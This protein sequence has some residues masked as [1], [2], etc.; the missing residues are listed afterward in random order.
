[1]PKTT[2]SEIEKKLPPTSKIMGWTVVIICVAFLVWCCYE[3]HRQNDL[4]PLA[5]IGGEIGAILTASFG[6]YCWRAKATD[7]FKITLLKAEL[8][9]QEGITINTNVPQDGE[10]ENYMGDESNGNYVE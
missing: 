4:A 3:M 2:K 7:T 8:E 5:Y 10:I 6:L 9:K 1:M